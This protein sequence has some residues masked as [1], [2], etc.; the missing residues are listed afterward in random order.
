MGIK[1]KLAYG[2]LMKAS[3]HPNFRSWLKKAI[4][5]AVV[6]G[7]LLFA[8]TISLISFGISQFNK[9]IS[10]N[11]EII[12]LDRLVNEQQIALTEEQKKAM[13]P[14]LRQFGRGE[15]SSENPDKIIAEI[16][17]LL[18]NRQLE[19]VTAVAE[20]MKADSTELKETGIS[21]VEEYISKYTG[22]SVQ[23]GRQ[24][25]E[26]ASGWWQ[27]GNSDSEAPQNLLRQIENSSGN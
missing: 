18:D 25:F 9:I 7:F 6:V 12:A 16:L 10:N 3:S 2:L 22:I 17:A 20:Q 14:L 27:S 11:Y 23:N 4:I 26:S 1:K 8:L 21:V 13:A 5:I 15:Q 19:S 24:L